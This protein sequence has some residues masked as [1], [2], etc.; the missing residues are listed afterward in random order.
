MPAKLTH[1]MVE[2]YVEQHKNGLLS[3]YVNSNTKLKLKCHCGNIF[4]KTFERFKAAKHKGCQSCTSEA[5]STAIKNSKT[6]TIHHVRSVVENDGC[7]LLSTTYE[8]QGDMLSLECPCGSEFTRS[9]QQFMQH[10]PNRCSGC[11][12]KVKKHSTDDVGEYLLSVGSV[13]LDPPY[14]N[15]SYKHSFECNTCSTPFSMRFA[16]LKRSA[17]PGQCPS[18]AS[19]RVGRENRISHNVVEQT[20]DRTGCSL[21]SQYITGSTDMDIQC[22]CGRVYSQSYNVF[23]TRE[24]NA[25]PRCITARTHGISLYVM[26]LLEDAEYLKDQ[27]ATKTAAEIASELGV[28]LQTVC[29]YFSEHGIHITRHNQSSGEREIVD[30]LRTII[31]E[32]IVTSSRSLIPPYEI[33]IYIPKYNIGIEYCGLYWHSDAVR[34]EPK[35]HRVKHNMCEDLGI[36]LIT[37]FE[38]EWVFKK[39]ILKSKFKSLLNKQT[40]SIYAR[41]TTVVNVS[42]PEAKLFLNM[43]HIQGHGPGSIRYGLVDSSGTM[44]ALMMFTKTGTTFTLTRFATSHRVV[45]GFSK[46]LKHFCNNHEWDHIVSFADNRYSTGKLYD[47]TG[48]MHVCTIPHD[49]NYVK[50]M[51]RYHKFAFR[52]QHIQNKF[53]NY[54]PNLSESENCKRNGYNK[55]WDCGK[56]KYVLNK[57]D[58]NK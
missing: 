37:V 11:T 39:D 31:D 29:N 56:R 41:S 15:N 12:G 38:D 3:Q 19:I 28:S 24:Y 2:Q 58:N 26:G 7:K 25:C 18:C 47:A 43:N 8:G 10:T 6:H 30:Y 14:I 42:L 57:A 55:I 54:D 22:H 49:Y 9:F 1:S 16:D 13:L 40:S 4:S 48:F 17:N 27:N 51:K 44:V 46:L 50:G 21:L 36:Q 52:H 34:D 53:D 32:D 35:Y 5:K 45:G 33:D 23:R 20:V